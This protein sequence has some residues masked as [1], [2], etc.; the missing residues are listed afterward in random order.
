M[1][2]FFTAPENITD[3]K[4]IIRGADVAHIRAV[5]RLEIGDRIQVLDGCGTCYIVTLNHVGRESIESH[6]DL[7]ENAD[8]C[9]SPLT[10]F[11]GQGMVKGTGF[12]GIVRR[13][14]ELGV[15]KIFPVSA[16]RC[17]S[18]LSPED[19]PKKME[20]WKRIAREAAKQCGRSRIP[21]ISPKPISVKEFCYANREAD[22]KLIFW[23]EERSTRIRNLPHRHDHKTAAVLI[24]PEG[25]FAS[26]EIESAIGYGFRSVSLG[27][28]LLRTDT[29]P[30]A[31]LSILQNHWGDL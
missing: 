11:L 3:E 29:A 23:E 27:P 24:G 10:I 18:K 5:L 22:L 14:V 31:V 21:D 9:E 7:K 17:I 30:L 28:R 20:R 2:R 1:H 25:G 19:I 15:G 26:G 6:I 12:D 16:K 13:A 4:A 8:D